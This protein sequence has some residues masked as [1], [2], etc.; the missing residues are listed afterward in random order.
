MSYYDIRSHGLLPL[1]S[2]CVFFYAYLQTSAQ[3]QGLGHPNNPSFQLR[4]IPRQNGFVAVS[5]GASMVHPRAL[6]VVVTRPLTRP[7]R[8]HARRHLIA[9]EVRVTL[10]NCQL[11]QHF[12]EGVHV[13]VVEELGDVHPTASKKWGESGSCCPVQVSRRMR[14]KVNVKVR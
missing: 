10:S 3:E 2:A 11:G 6:H 1:Q 9:H 7:P 4:I 5:T 13:G 14:E 12:V 8:Q